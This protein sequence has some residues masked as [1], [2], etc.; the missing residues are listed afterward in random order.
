MT[1]GPFTLR[2]TCWVNLL[3]H[4]E[5]VTEKKGFLS[6]LQDN[7]DPGFDIYFLLIYGQMVHIFRRYILIY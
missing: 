4:G 6:D 1:R 3:S 2:T 7:K 5:N